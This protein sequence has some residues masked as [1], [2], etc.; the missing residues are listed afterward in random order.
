ML[1]EYRI[2]AITMSDKTDYIDRQAAK[3]ACLKY[4]GVG[5]VWSQILDEIEALPSAQQCK[6]WDSESNH[7]ALYRPSAQP[8]DAVEVVR[9]KDCKKY[10][11]HDHRCKYWNH[12]VVVMD[13]CNK[14]ERK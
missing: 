4:N 7:C 5:W 9:C 12:G 8:V 11:T 1:E 14:G 10:D 13:Y 2:G 3:E 6:Y